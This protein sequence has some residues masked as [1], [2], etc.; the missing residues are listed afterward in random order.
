MCFYLEEF[1]CSVWGRATES[2]QFPTDIELVT[3]A[4]ICDFNVHVGIQE[5][6]LCLQEEEEEE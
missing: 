5:K 4:K 1:R 6:V 2:V 3:E